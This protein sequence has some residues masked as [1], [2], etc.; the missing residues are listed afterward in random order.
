MNT[1]ILSIVVSAFAIMSSAIAMYSNALKIKLDSAKLIQSKA[2]KLSVWQK[3]QKPLTFLTP[4]LALSFLALN[5]DPVSRSFVIIV[6][7]LFTFL[8][9]NVVLELILIVLRYM[10]RRDGV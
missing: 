8:I 3:L 7:A 10:Y 1:E 9:C 2:T 6:G 4:L 5:A